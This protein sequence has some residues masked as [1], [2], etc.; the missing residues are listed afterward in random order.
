MRAGA[1][2]LRARAPGLPARVRRLGLPFAA[3]FACALSGATVALASSPDS[4][5]SAPQ[6]Q[7]WRGDERSLRWESLPDSAR[8]KLPDRWIVAST[9]EAVTADRTL[10]PGV[11]YLLDARRGVL[12]WLVRPVPPLALHYRFVPLAI[13]AEYR[14]RRLSGPPPTAGGTPTGAPGDS[15]SGGEESSLF[16]GT[17]LA[18]REPGFS[19]ARLSESGGLVIAGSKTVSVEVGT[20]SDL[21]FQQSLDLTV[22][23]QLSPDVSVR[24]ILTDRNTPLE[25]EGTSTAL[26]DLDRVL[27]QVE[28]SAARMTLGDFTLR[29]EQTQFAAL[30]RQL[31]GV[32]GEGWKREGR[33]FATGATVPGR[34]LSVEF[35]GEEGKQG[36]YRLLANL[37]SDRGAIVAGSERVYLEGERLVRGE[38]RDY[39]IDY[40]EGTIQF[41]PRRLISSESRV[42]V[43]VQVATES[44]RRNLYG[45]GVSFGAERGDPHAVDPSAGTPETQVGGGAGP[46]I[47]RDD[48]SAPAP[49]APVV[50]SGG[51]RM[52]LLFL[53][54]RD[55]ASHPLGVGLS[56][57]E[58]AA[59]AAAGDS[60]TDALR[61]GIERVGLG[62]GDYNRVE[63]D[64][65]ATPFFLF[66]GEGQGNYRVRF[67]Q[68]GAGNGDYRDTTL[69]GV[70]DPVFVFAGRRKADFLPGREVPRPEAQSMLSVAGGVPE[71]WNLELGLSDFDR[72]ELSSK[73]DD[74]NQGLALSAEGRAPPLEVAGAE[75]T[76]SGRVRQLDGRFHP[77]DRLDPSYFGLDWNLDPAR[78]ESGDRRLGGGLAVRRGRAAVDLRAERLDNL[79]DFDA[80]RLSFRAEAGGPGLRFRGRWLRTDS[81]DRKPGADSDGLRLRRE[82][83]LSRLGTWLR[84]SG[85][86][87]GERTEGGTF[88]DSTRGEAVGDLYH[89][90]GASVGLGSRF[91]RLAASVGYVRRETYLLE[92]LDAERRVSVAHTHDLSL[93]WTGGGG[94]SA[95][96]DLSLRRIRPAGAGE[97]RSGLATLRS[98][99]SL[100]S[101]RVSQ[102]LRFD[103]SS[104]EQTDRLKELRFVGL[105]LGHYDSLGVYQGIGDFEVFYQDLAGGRRLQQVEAVFRHEFEPSGRAELGGDAPAGVVAALVRTLHVVHVLTSRFGADRELDDLLGVLGPSLLGRVE[106]PTTEVESR[107]DL[108]AFPAA[109]LL[110][111]RARWEE[112][113]SAVELAGGS[114]EESR[115]RTLSGRLR[116]RPRKGWSVDLEEEWERDARRLGPGRE[117]GWRSLKSS[118]EQRVSLPRGW[119]PALDASHRNRRRLERAE[120][121]QVFEL[122][123]SLV[124]APNPRARLEGRTTRTSLRRRHGTSRLDY[125]LEKPGWS[126][127]FLGTLHLRSAFDLSFTLRESRPDGGR[128][129][130]DG[131]LELRATF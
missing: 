98:H 102:D 38:A 53:T 130:R 60:I 80:S 16:G 126:T 122:T 82:A 65:L 69:A 29:G 116:S 52:H 43:D 3:A 19:F 20:Q 76:V 44:Y 47:W 10:R 9:F 112:S 127:R 114:R 100:G 78:L 104:A 92:P 67:E 73:D 81:R 68:V 46:P 56:A 125:D 79:K 113:K 71:R 129:L 55:R 131:R 109:R 118:L 48:P 45:G 86:Y 74:D 11:D 64:T 84:L 42:A 34:F 31:E 85:R 32:Q 25:P 5:V 7:V 90:E 105:G 21:R 15:A 106:H 17:L 87:R 18:P 103:L 110:S 88:V 1:R 37:P 4:V 23:G 108:S 94:Q 12:R 99:R 36:P 96:A 24:A 101:E 128:R 120:R 59:L 70:P 83:E 30:S 123:P 93:T 121:A 41:T 63:N 111:P 95:G 89:E 107:L 35:R 49:A 117:T 115:R 28:G 26:E 6:L 75:I 91:E 8:V 50:S 62:E 77:L 2:D 27:L 97:T 51:A 40:A 22:N 33:L 39:V 54:E 14:R 61:S 119:T 66:V 57:A 124:W 58:K 72:N 13:E